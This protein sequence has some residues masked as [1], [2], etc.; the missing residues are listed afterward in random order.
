MK[1]TNMIDH[2]WAIMQKSLK[3]VDLKIQR[4]NFVLSEDFKGWIENYNNDY[5]YF[6]FNYFTPLSLWFNCF[7]FVL[8]K[9]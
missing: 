6:S 9:S 7:W 5:P 1:N 2:S 4:L 3:H 8:H